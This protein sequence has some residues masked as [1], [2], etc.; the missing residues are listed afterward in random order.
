MH[1][2]IINPG[3]VVAKYFNY[4]CNRKSINAGNV[5]IQVKYVDNSKLPVYAAIE[6]IRN[7]MKI[8]KPTAAASPIPMKMLRINSIIIISNV[9]FKWNEEQGSTNL[10]L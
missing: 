2:K 10:D 7:G 9:Y 1:P 4:S 3:N 8:R 6:A 5:P